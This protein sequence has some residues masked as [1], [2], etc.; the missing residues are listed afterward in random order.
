MICSVCLGIGAFL[1]GFSAPQDCGVDQQTARTGEASSGKRDKREERGRDG[2]PLTHSRLATSSPNQLDP[3]QD[4]KQTQ[5]RRGGGGFETR[6]LHF[7]C[8]CVVVAI[9]SNCL[10]KIKRIQTEIK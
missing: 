5:K 10:G 1:V 4:G 2:F 8:V 3:K 9:K 7:V 6:K